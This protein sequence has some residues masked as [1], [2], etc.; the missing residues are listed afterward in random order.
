MAFRSTSTRVFGLPRPHI[1]L[2]NS[3]TIEAVRH[4]QALT[5]FRSL[6]VKELGF[7]SAMGVFTFVCR[8]SGDEWT[9]KSVSGELEASAGSTFDLQRKLVQTALCADSSGGVQSSFSFVTPTSGV[10]QVSLSLFPSLCL[11]SF[12][13]GF[14]V[15]I[16]GLILPLFSFSF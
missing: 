2:R 13:D 1:R 8:N 7:R 9:G 5:L 16:L 3:I 6:F 11:L 14:F 12:F 15:R 10:F 4:T